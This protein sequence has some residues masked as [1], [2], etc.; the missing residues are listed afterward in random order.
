MYKEIK[1]KIKKNDHLCRN[2]HINVHRPPPNLNTVEQA[3]TSLVPSLSNLSEYASMLLISRIEIYFFSSLVRRQIPRP[4]IVI[5]GRSEQVWARKRFTVSVGRLFDGCRVKV[6][7]KVP[8]CLT[9]PTI[10]CTTSKS[11]GWND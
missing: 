9:N 10:Q 1:P 3:Q 5:N 8:T 7:P 11:P 6:V 4:R 2:L